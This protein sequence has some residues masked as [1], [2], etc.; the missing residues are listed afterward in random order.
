MDQLSTQRRCCVVCG[1]WILM[2]SAPAGVKLLAN[3]IIKSLPDKRAKIATASFQI[4]VLGWRNGACDGISSAQ[5]HYQWLFGKILIDM[6]LLS[7]KFY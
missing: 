5:N 7:S 6:F 1:R 2:Q 4:L 3:Y